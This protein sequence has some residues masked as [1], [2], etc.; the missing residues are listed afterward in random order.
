M[1]QK[2]F[3]SDIFVRCYPTGVSPALIF[4]K[5]LRN[6]RLLAKYSEYVNKFARWFFKEKSPGNKGLAI[7]KTSAAF[8]TY[9]GKPVIALRIYLLNPF[10]KKQKANEIVKRLVSAKKEFDRLNQSKV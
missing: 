6:D 5:E 1:N 8:Y 7:S 2:H 9:T 3:G 10:I 4:P